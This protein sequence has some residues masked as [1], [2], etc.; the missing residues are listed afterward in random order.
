[1]GYL[2]KCVEK[3]ISTLRELSALPYVGYTLGSQQLR[4][5]SLQ[6]NLLFSVA[7]P[8]LVSAF[9]TNTLKEDEKVIKKIHYI[10]GMTL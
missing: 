10:S 3:E 2:S 6:G 9:V 4:L 1:M 5:I 8:S 7:N